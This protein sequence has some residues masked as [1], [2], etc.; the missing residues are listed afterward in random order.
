MQN[1]KLRTRA[2]ID[3]RI[4]AIG[5]ELAFHTIE[6]CRANHSAL[7]AE[8]AELRAEHPAAERR[9]GLEAL[10]RRNATTP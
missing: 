9:E 3:L 10:Q 4:E 5:N 2:E 6:D 1:T 7:L 8:L